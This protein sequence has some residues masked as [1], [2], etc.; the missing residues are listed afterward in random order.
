MKANSPRSRILWSAL[1]VLIAGASVFV[2]ISQSRTFTLETFLDYLQRFSPGW[3]ACAFAAMLGFIYF[4]GEAVSSLVR[5]FGCP[6][7]RS[8]SL[9]YSASDLYFS[10]ITPSAT[11]GQPMCAY[12]MVKDGVPPLVATVA[13]IANL[14]MYTAAIILIGAATLLAH[15]AV[16]LTFGTV[17]RL[18]IVLGFMVQAGL[19]IFFV[20]LLFHSRLMSRICSGVLWLLCRL[21]LLRHEERRRASLEKHM[22]DYALYAGMIK[23]HRAALGR[24]F[25]LNLLQRLS[26][27]TVP[28]FLYLASGGSARI[29]SRVWAVQCCTILGSNIVPIPGA[30]GVSDYIMLDGLADL[31]PAR[32]VVDFELLSRGVSFYVLVLLCGAVTLAAYLNV[33]RK[34]KD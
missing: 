16:F 34:S 11:G 17:S 29:A 24:A 1:F 31:I 18:L 28:F 9:V 30:M 6:V 4:E 3:I 2:I 5:S 33:R 27:I 32:D 21:K 14:A 23:E 15:P 10:A 19:L 25:I 8:R 20:L 22:S 7:G 26:L 12:F 13:L